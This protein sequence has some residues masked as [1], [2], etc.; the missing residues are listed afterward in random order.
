MMRRAWPVAIVFVAGAAH[1]GP[2]E[3]GDSFN[4]SV[5]PLHLLLPLVELQA[6]VYATPVVSL[7]AIGGAGQATVERSGEPDQT[8]DVW[9]AGGQARAY[10]FGSTQEG[11]FAGAEVLYAHVSGRTEGVTGLG[12]GT[13]I[14][15]IVG[16]KWVWDG[17]FLL[18]L[19]GGVGYLAVSAEAHD[20]TDEDS[21]SDSQTIPILNFNLGWAF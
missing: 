21:Q 5:S 17:G 4:V 18:D 2:K 7:A 6:E 14:G 10:F 12:A 19:N 13:E 3:H 15:G 20:S 9:E 1:A 16:Y 11:A 8:Y